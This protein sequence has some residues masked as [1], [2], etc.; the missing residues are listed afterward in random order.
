GRRAPGRGGF[1]IG[2]VG[3]GRP[4]A[5]GWAVTLDELL[6]G[7]E[8]ITVMGSRTVEV[9]GL[10]YDS[11]QVRPGDTFFALPGA[12]HDG[13]AFVAD[14]LA[15]GAAAIVTA[16]SIEAPVP[17]VRVPDARVALAEAACTFYGAPSRELRVVGVTGTNG[18]TTVTYLLEGVFRRA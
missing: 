10:A 8:G 2:L 3:G 17:V 12:H 13:T 16:A 5:N 6:S 11:R 7:L 1:A 4:P 9:T 14:S 18:K 15:R